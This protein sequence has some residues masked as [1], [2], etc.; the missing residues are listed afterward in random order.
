MSGPQ[1]GKNASGVPSAD[2]SGLF[3]TPATA[4]VPDRTEGVPKLSPPP[5]RPVDPATP[6]QTSS[7]ASTLGPAATPATAGGPAAAAPARRTSSRSSKASRHPSSVVVYLSVTLRQRLR[8]NAGATSRSHT[9]IVFAAL[10]ASH[11]RLADLAT[12]SGQQPPEQPADGLFVVQQSGRRLH[13]ED[14]VQ[15]SIRP[16]PANLAVI[17][18]LAA[19]HTGGNRSALI[20]L[21]LDDY[22]PSDG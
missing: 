22:L 13:D 10:N 3:G 2:L 20:A 16:N 19:Q 12:R 8:V 7:S 17:D 4:A 9:Q 21:A 1:L 6:L 15:V 14:Q 5:N 18:Q 11:S